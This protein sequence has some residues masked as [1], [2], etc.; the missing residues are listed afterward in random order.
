MIDTDRLCSSLGEIQLLSIGIIHIVD[1]ISARL[2]DEG[3]KS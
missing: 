2:I 1:H 3:L